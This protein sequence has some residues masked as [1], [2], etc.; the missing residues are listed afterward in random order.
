MKKNTNEAYKRKQH[1][2][3]ISPKQVSRTTAGQILLYLHMKADCLMGYKVD[4]NKNIPMCFM[5]Y[6][7]VSP[8]GP[9]R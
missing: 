8:L 3:F 1:H 4:F 7:F 5:L 6:I 2:N 9:A